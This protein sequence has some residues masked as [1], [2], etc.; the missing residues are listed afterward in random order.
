MVHEATT[1][2]QKSDKATVLQSSQHRAA[3]RDAISDAS[4]EL[5]IVSPWLRTA[6]VDSELIGWLQTALDQKT[7]LRITVAYGIQKDP[8]APKDPMLKNQEEAIRRLRRIGER[9]KGR[10]QVV[11]IGNTHEKVVICDD[12][13]VIFTSFNFLSF[14]PQPGKGIRREMGYRVI[15]PS[16]V[17]QVKRLI[18]TAIAE[19]DQVGGKE[20][21]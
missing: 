10:L 6:A 8:K 12:R 7:H 2:A 17:S 13:Y 11:D 9:A 15:D 16:T 20:R 1:E 3:L 21:S 18:A 19:A 14:N 5:I 4:R